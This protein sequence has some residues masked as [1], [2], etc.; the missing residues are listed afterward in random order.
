[1]GRDVQRFVRVHVHHTLHTAVQ[2]RVDGLLFRTGC[3][4]VAAVNDTHRIYADVGERTVVAKVNGHRASQH[5]VRNLFRHVPGVRDR[6]SEVLTGRRVHAHFQVFRT[7]TRV[8]VL[9]R[10]GKTVWDLNTVVCNLAK[11]DTEV[12]HVP[13]HPF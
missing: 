12:R 7:R 11:I 2:F 4:D 10:L 5:R 8:R 6:R 1:M 13:S 3:K 9:A